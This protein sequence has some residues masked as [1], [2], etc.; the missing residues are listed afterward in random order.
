MHANFRKH[1]YILLGFQMGP[2]PHILPT[3]T[4][5]IFLFRRYSS[6]V[7]KPLDRGLDQELTSRT[8]QADHL[9]R[10]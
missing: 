6:I 4:E 1:F 3:K 10:N 8:H 7:E 2:L 5:C 9:Y